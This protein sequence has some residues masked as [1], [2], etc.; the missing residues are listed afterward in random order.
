[1]EI[2]YATKALE[3]LCTDEKEMA[4]K[5]ADIADKLKLRVNALR[6]AKDFV[7]LQ[8]ID[9]GG[10]WHELQANL[11]GAWSGRLSRN[12][13]LLVRPDGDGQPEER[14]EATILDLDDYH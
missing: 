9:Q 14:N 3:K 13:R 2:Y 12:W 1:M 4:K 10:K 11:A 8:R 6:E 7:D 5:R